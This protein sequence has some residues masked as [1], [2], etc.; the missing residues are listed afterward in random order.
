[1]Y[2][3]KMELNKLK[4][5]T[6]SEDNHSNSLSMLCMLENLSKTS[7]R[8]IPDSPIS[9]DDVESNGPFILSTLII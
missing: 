9:T 7:C 8:D 4:I 1:M 2:I 6:P 5:N 3:L